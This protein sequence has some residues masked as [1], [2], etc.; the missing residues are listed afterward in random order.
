MVVF[1]LQT[2]ACRRSFRVSPAWP[3]RRVLL[4]GGR[5]DPGDRR[6]PDQYLLVPALVWLFLRR[7]VVGAGLHAATSCPAEARDGLPSPS[8]RR[9]FE[10]C[11]RM[12]FATR[13]PSWPAPMTS[14]EAKECRNGSPTK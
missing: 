11:D 1:H 6:I 2:P 4:N 13:L 3:G 5:R 7:S 8:R 10:P 9:P 12:C 14:M